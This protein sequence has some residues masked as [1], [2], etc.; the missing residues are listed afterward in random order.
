MTTATYNSKRHGCYFGQG[1]PRNDI[2]EE[3]RVRTGSGKLDAGAVLGKVFD[4]AP[5]VTP[6]TPVS[7]IGGTV[8]NGAIGA[9][10]ADV[11]APEGSWTLELT[12]AGATA[13]YKVVRPDGSLDGIGTVGSAYNGG[14]N[15]TLADGANDW[16]AGDI[17]P[18]VVALTSRAAEYVPH[19]P[20]LTNGGQVAAAILF[21]GIDATSADVKA[22]A[23]TRGPAT[24]NGNMLTFKSGISAND[25]AAAI[26]ALRDK[27][28]AVL[29]QHAA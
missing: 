2:N 21:A 8:G 23:T 5:G 29:P 27:G 3:I 25:K 1:A 26:Q 15:G 10:T 28:M 9:W 18:M 14:I 24:I 17:I 22:V 7:T 13:K 16:I 19:D 12:T 20:V 6:G 11:G 4:V